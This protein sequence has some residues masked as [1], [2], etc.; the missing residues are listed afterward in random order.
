MEYNYAQRK[1]VKLPLIN[2][3]PE[4]TGDVIKYMWYEVDD[5]DLTGSVS[6]SIA[7]KFSKKVSTTG[8][9]RTW[10]V[11]PSVSGTVLFN[12]KDDY[13]GDAFVN[14]CDEADGEGKMYNTGSMLFWIRQIQ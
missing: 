7:G 10:E 5:P 11:G 4:I 1:G 8:T 13:L 9:D 3:N 2:W 6:V 14:Y 12:P